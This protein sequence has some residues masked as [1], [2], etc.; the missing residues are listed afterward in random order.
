MADSQIRWKKGDYIR[1]GQAVALHN[2]LI[3]QHRNLEN[4]L[5]LPEVLEYQDLKKKITTRRELNRVINSL[6]RIQA[7]DAFDVYETEAGELITKWERRELGLQ[8]KIAQRR[9]KNELKELNTPTESGYSRAQM[10]HHRVR[11]IEAQLRNLRKIETRTGYEFNALRRRL[12]NVGTSDYEMRRAIQYRENYFSMIKNYENFDNYDKLINKLQSITNPIE[13][14]KF[15]SQNELLSDITY[16]YD[17]LVN[18]GLGIANEQMN[19]DYMLESIGIE[20]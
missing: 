13:F 19:F 16:M 14:Y 1:L 3:N 6:R 7:E 17:N 8:S 11:E 12:A 20:V 18:F 9:L 4:T 5:Q 2:R 15:V 10:G